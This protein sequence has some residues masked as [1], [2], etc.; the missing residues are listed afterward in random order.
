M[1]TKASRSDG[2]KWSASPDGLYPMLSLGKLGTGSDSEIQDSL[3]G[4][5]WWVPEYHL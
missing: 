1:I 5:V 2:D 4:V 3:S